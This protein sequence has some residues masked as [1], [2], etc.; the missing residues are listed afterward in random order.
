MYVY[1]YIY[2]YI[3]VMC[4]YIYIYVSYMFV[5][6]V[7]LLKDLLLGTSLTCLT[8]LPDGV[9]TSGVFTEGPQSPYML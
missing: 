7:G 3:Y 6:Y 1:I 4:V 5:S 8:G 9:G 2:I